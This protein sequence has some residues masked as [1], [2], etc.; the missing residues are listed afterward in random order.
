VSIDEHHE[1]CFLFLFSFLLSLYS[2]GRK[3]WWICIS[4]HSVAFF[5]ATGEEVLGSEV[6]E[7]GFHF[8]LS[9]TLLFRYS[10]Y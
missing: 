1:H 6:L 10:V 5:E 7:I 2:Q 4:R 8:C 3:G 9:Y